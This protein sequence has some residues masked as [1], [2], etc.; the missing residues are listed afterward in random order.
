MFDYAEL[1]TRVRAAELL[2]SLGKVTD[3]GA[4][5]VLANL[6]GAES[7]HDLNEEQQRTLEL[8]AGPHGE[9]YYWVLK[10]RE[11]ENDR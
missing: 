3:D 1:M 11:D 5:T 6:L 10:S 4:Y 7:V 2:T 9:V 8:L